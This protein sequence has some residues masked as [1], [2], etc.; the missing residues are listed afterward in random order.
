MAGVFDIETEDDMKE[1]QKNK[2]RNRTYNYGDP[3]EFILETSEKFGINLNVL[4]PYRLNS[5]KLGDC[6]ATIYQIYLGD[7]H[8]HGREIRIIPD[9]N[10]CYYDPKAEFPNSTVERV[11]PGFAKLIDGDSWQGFWLTEGLKFF[12]KYK[13]DISLGFWYELMVDKEF[14]ERSGIDPENWSQNGAVFA[15][16]KNGRFQ[17][18][19]DTWD[20]VRDRDSLLAKFYMDVE[21]VSKE[22]FRPYF[23][24]TLE[25]IVGVPKEQWHDPRIYHSENQ[26]EDPTLNSLV[27]TSIKILFSGDE[28]ISIEQRVAEARLRIREGYISVPKLSLGNIILPNP[29]MKVVESDEFVLS[30]A[31]YVVEY[32]SALGVLDSKRAEELIAKKLENY[33]VHRRGFQL[34]MDKAVEILS[35]LKQ[36]DYQETS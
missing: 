10:I 2:Q 27:D 24:R 12:G 32:L 22:D 8:T 35:Q 34:S 31:P 19:Y 9:F 17:F 5:K 23:R 36:A 3:L 7:R 33:F 26:K 1:R 25:L 11:K 29:G 30:A 16:W 13:T 4:Y 15:I 18:D 20:R 6:N 14:I 28:R 21:K